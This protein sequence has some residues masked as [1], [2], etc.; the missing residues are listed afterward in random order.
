V[1][2]LALADELQY[3]TLIACPVPQRDFRRSFFFV[4]HK[5]KFRSQALERWLELCRQQDL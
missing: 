4:L 2:R 3:R 1:S 5:R